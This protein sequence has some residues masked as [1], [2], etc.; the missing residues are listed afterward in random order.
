MALFPQLIGHT[1]LNWAVRWISPTLV[2]L[3]ILFEPLGSSLLGWLV[4]ME[5]PPLTVIWG[6][7][8]LLVG[9]AIAVIGNRK[10]PNPSITLD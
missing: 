2:T 4:F 3:A 5:I 10:P 6:G 1:S 9:V 8:I 7:L